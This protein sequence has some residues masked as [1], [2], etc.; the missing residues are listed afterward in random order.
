MNFDFSWK[1]S[2]CCLNIYGFAFLAIIV[3]FAYKKYRSWSSSLPR[4]DIDEQFFW[5][6]GDVKDYKEDTSIK[7][8]KVDITQQVI[9]RLKGKLDDA[10]KAQE[11]L[12]GVGFEYGFNGNK[13]DQIVD[14][15]SNTYLKKW[16]ERQEFLNQYPQFKTQI[17]GYFKIFI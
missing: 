4:P 17:Q 1:M 13:L 8:F 3:A 2:C 7:P 5:G 16:S 15:W 9:D 6:R 12:E 14:Y 10:P 11:P